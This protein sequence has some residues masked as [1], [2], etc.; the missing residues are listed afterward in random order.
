MY[1]S[2]RYGYITIGKL[3]SVDGLYAMAKLVIVV[4]V[5]IAKLNFGASILGTQ[6]HVEA[7]IVETMSRVTAMIS[8]NDFIE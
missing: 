6:V 2:L 7:Q 8:P 5:N 1:W 3:R 4:N